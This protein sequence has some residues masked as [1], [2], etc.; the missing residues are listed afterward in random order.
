VTE[1]LTCVICHKPE[2]QA[3][4]C[5]TCTS[6]MR[7]WLVELAG[8]AA[9]LQEAVL[10]RLTSRRGERVQVLG[11][12]ETPMPYD[13]DASEVEW[14]LHNTLVA[15]VRSLCEDRGITYPGVDRSSSLAHWLSRN[16][17]AIAL[18]P[19]ALETYDLIRHLAVGSHGEEER[20]RRSIVLSIVDVPPTRVWMGRCDTT[21]EGRPCAQDV[22]AALDDVSVR[23]SGCQVTHNVAE[24]Q[25]RVLTA[26][27][28]QL[29]TAPEI[30][31]YLRGAVKPAT[32]R[33]WKKR[34]RMKA[35]PG[36]E[37]GGL[38][39]YLIGEVLDVIA[40]GREKMSA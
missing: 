15:I 12:G 16:V 22:R 14:I 1:T 20:W 39:L 25:A 29:A 7:T 10:P 34:G 23:C 6:E 35:V 38:D 11:T 21:I 13:P 19:D 26:M 17:E 30:L 33:Q 36:V 24:F 3:F 27:A 37:R 31:G 28:G 32:F 9:D 40:Q 2:A 5:P 4:A 18:S 8:H